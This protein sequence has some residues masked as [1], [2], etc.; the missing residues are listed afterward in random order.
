MVGFENCTGLTLP[1]SL[2]RIHDSAFN[3]F[4]S[5]RGEVDPLNLIIPDSVT[6]IGQD[7]F[8]DSPFAFNTTVISGINCLPR[9]TANSY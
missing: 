2:K 9:S 1:S 7:A 5:V 6:Y 3:N 8:K 4:N